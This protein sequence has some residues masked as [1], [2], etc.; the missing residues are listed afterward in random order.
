M[1]DSHAH[2]QQQLRRASTSLA[3]AMVAAILVT[4]APGRADAAAT[5]T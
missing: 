3:L 4:L 1:P 5:C 2:V